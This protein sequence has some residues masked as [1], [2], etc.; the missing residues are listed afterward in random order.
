MVKSEKQERTQFKLCKPVGL[1]A[2]FLHPGAFSQKV[3]NQKYSAVYFIDKKR[4]I[5]GTQISS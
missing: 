2:L 1:A 4:D 5:G 3:I